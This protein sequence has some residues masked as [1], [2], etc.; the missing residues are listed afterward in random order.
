MSANSVNTSS[1]VEGVPLAVFFFTGNPNLSKRIAANCLGLAGLN[2]SP[3]TVSMSALI[4]RISASISALKAANFATSTS[5]P[6]RSICPSTRLTG[7]S[8][9][10]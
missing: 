8:T 10:R 2:F 1:S 9:V 3:A 6:V 4:R 7:S 5:T